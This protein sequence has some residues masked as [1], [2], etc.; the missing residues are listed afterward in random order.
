[1]TYSKRSYR[2]RK[3][4]A[5]SK[6]TG[7]VAKNK[8]AIAKLAKQTLAYRQYQGIT[9]HE[10]GQMIY[11]KQEMIPSEW[12]RIFQT[13]GMTDAEIPRVYNITSL[14]C[15]YVF[16]CGNNST[17]NL[18]LQFMVFSL[19][20]NVRAQWI[21]RT[22]DGNSLV[23]DK[24]YTNLA[25]DSVEGLTDG[26]SAFTL[27]PAY[28]NVHHDTGMK[29]IGTTTMEGA[30]LTNIRDS[31]FYGEK[32]LKWNKTFKAGGHRDKG[33]EELVAIDVNHSSRLYSVVFSNATATAPLFQSVSW[34]ING[35]T[36]RN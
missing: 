23:Q 22:N 27:N 19:K 12:V 15:K 10:I 13:K 36:V 1:M 7:Q 25:M 4:A 16:Q 21:D 6:P 8:S 32:R 24:D 33:V 18:W 30:D 31:T 20:P 2:K 11:T 28:F 3:P 17:D 14:H 26:F 29:R 34:M 9:T 35:T 5:K